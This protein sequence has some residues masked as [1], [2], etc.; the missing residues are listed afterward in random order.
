M[1]KKTI[2]AQIPSELDAHLAAAA[3]ARHCS[4]SDIIRALIL[5]HCRQVPTVGSATAQH[6]HEVDTNKETCR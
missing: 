2:S 1:D 4:K 6:V 5:D 3:K